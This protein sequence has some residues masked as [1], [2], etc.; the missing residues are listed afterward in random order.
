MSYETCVKCSRGRNPASPMRWH[1]T[2]FGSVCDR[3]FANEPPPP[4]P[5]QEA[6]MVVV[7]CPSCRGAAT[8][9]PCETCIGY[10]SVRVEANALPVYRVTAAKPPG[11]LTETTT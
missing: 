1:Q 7:R 10:G 6:E 2:N 4:T 8:V 11:T 5:A 9:S 3:C